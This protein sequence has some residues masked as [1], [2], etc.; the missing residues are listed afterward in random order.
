MILELNSCGN[1]LYP[2]LLCTIAGP[3]GTIIAGLAHGGLKTS[4]VKYLKQLGEQLDGGKLRVR[5]R[6]C[7]ELDVAW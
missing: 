6:R 3:M 2:E 5:S 4:T 7:I 1:V